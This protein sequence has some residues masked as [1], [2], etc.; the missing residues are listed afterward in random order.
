M[1][2]NEGGAM[3]GVGPIHIDEIDP[4]L[5]AL[6]KKLGIDLRSN[7]LGSVGKK[8]FSGDIDVAVQVSTD[9][10]PELVKKLEAMPEVLDIAKSSVIMTSVNIVGYDAN[11]KSPD[12]SKPRTGKVQVDFM[13]GDPGWMKTYY[14]APSEKESKYKGVFRNVMIA[15]IASILDRKDST[16]TIDDGRPTESER[17][18]WS[19]TD[20]L[21]RIK[22]TPV[23]KKNGEGYTKKNQNVMIDGPYKNPNDIAKKLKLDDAK[24]LNSYES[25]KAAMEKNYPPK[26]VQSILDNFSESGI[27]KDIGVPDDLKTETLAD[28]NYNRVVALSKRLSV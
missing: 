22:R 23:P 4:T 28:K 10:I 21:V 13:P 3:P 25:L 18:M 26:L 12:P 27:V 9:Q 24:D 17:W 8:E 15:T 14:H 5:S 11:K 2:L 7:V 20:G 19:P 6:E 16:D 1:I